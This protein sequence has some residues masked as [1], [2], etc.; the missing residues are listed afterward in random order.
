[1]YTDFDEDKYLKALS[2]INSDEFQERDWLYGHFKLYKET[3]NWPDNLPPI[4]RSNL[5]KGTLR[6]KFNSTYK[7]ILREFDYRM[8]N[9]LKTIEIKQTEY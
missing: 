8:D 5:I 2:E 7:E 6:E 9:K 1:M 4:K 3:L